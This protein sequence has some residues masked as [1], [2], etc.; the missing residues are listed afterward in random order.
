MFILKS[1]FCIHKTFEVAAVYARFARCQQQGL[2]SS[3]SMKKSIFLTMQWIPYTHCSQKYISKGCKSDKHD[4]Q[5]QKEAQQLNYPYPPWTGKPTLV[6]DRNTSRRTIGA[7]LV[8]RLDLLFR[9]GGCTERGSQV[10]LDA[11]KLHREDVRRSPTA[12]YSSRCCRLELVLHQL[13]LKE[14]HINEGRK[15][16]GR[17]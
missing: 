16:G 14:H 17:T 5:S 7:C 10:K 9:E 12:R 1:E 6:Q 15:E 3:Q 13:S 8:Y 2:H 4:P 11:A